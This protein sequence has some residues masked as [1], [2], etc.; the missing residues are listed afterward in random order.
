MMIDSDAKCPFCG[1]GRIKAKTGGQDCKAQGPVQEIRNF[2]GKTTMND[3]TR[4]RMS[5]KALF[6][7]GH[8]YLDVD[9]HEWILAAHGERVRADLAPEW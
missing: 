7:F 4:D 5:E 1:G 8:G 3:A 2:D 6:F 9:E